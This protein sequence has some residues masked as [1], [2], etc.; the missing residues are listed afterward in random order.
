MGLLVVGSVALDT[1]ETPFGRIEE[2]RATV[3]RIVE[4]APDTRL[5]NLRERYLFANSL[6]FDRIVADLRIGS[7]V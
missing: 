3:R 5:A 7:I 6:G 1:V 2:A 4:I